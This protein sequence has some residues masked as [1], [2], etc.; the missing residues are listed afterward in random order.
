VMLT[1]HP[2]LVLRLR[3]SRSYTSSPLKRRHGV[4]RDSFTSNIQR[5]LAQLSGWN[6][7]RESGHST[8]TETRY[9]IPHEWNIQNDLTARIIFQVKRWLSSGL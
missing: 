4:W 9:E 1:T 6:S 2:L 8:E 7:M 5:V 3:M